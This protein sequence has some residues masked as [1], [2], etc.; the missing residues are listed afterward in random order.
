MRNFF[1]IVALATCIAG[2]AHAKHPQCAGNPEPD[3]CE[4]IRDDLDRETPIQK[5]AR[6]QNAEKGRAETSKVVN[7]QPAYSSSQGT[8]DIRIGM[9]AY[10]ARNSRWGEPS[11]VNKT[12]TALGVTEQWVYGINRYLY[13]TNGTLTAIQD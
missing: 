3:K 1:T 6:I 5:S 13:F 10:D 9:S 11:R 8:Y 7:A 2:L 12:T 4:K